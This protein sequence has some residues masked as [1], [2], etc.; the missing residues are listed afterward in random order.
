MD[1]DRGDADGL[2][3]SAHAPVARA[4]DDR[5]GDAVALPLSDAH[6]AD[7]T[8]FWGPASGGVRRYIGAKHRYLERQAGC[9]HSTVVP[10]SGAARPAGRGARAA[11]ASDTGEVGVPSLPL[12]FAPGYRVARS[13]RAAVD[14][15]VRLQPDV[16][17][18]GDPYNLAWAALDAA[19]ALDVPA[20]AFAHSDLPA[21]A[22]RVGGA[23]GQALAERYLARLYP[24]FDRVLAPSRA[25]CARLRQL[26]ARAE[27]QPLGVDTRCF[28]PHRRDPAWRERL[29]I[30]DDQRIVLYAGR[31]APEKN[32]P[33]LVQAVARLG[34]RYV[35][36]LIGDG[37]VRVADGPFAGQVRALPFEREP[38]ALARALA[39]CDVFAHAGDI[40]TFGLA[41]LEAMACGTPVVVQ[42]R[43]GLADLVDA[44]VGA[45]IDAPA[46]E[47]VAAFA[48]AIRRLCDEAGTPAAAARR[49]AARRRA[50]A[51][52]WDVLLPQLA[53]RYASLIHLRATRLG[54]RA[55]T[56][57][58]RTVAGR[59][60]APDELLA[61]AAA[62]GAA[63]FA[64]ADAM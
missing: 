9:S 42:R 39:S 53:Q 40:E 29:A 46:G 26:G 58:N 19:D 14:V 7:L 44:R 8:M 2:A 48:S 54:A 10:A 61:L 11:V 13:R 63:Q 64:C 36:V 37:P 56:G 15:L 27:W 41:P 25:L 55:R 28:A 38:L 23:R 51:H 5:A 43:G 31:F 24:R 17:E 50:L 62:A 52:D 34:P 16:I 60:R 4:V 22:A 33:L 6:V 45:A 57:D 3:A 1:G 18:A 12:P 30:D 21:L 49:L 20:I 47:R 35:L 32:L 59:L